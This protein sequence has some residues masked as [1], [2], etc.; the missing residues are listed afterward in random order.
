MRRLR[1]DCAIR[2]VVLAMLLTAG[3][4]SSDG[5]P[6]ATDDDQQ[7]GAKR[8]LSRPH[9]VM[10]E[11]FAKAIAEKDYKTAYAQMSAEYQKDLGEKEFLDSVKRYR[12]GC[13]AVPSFEIAATE[14]DVADLKEDSVIELLVPEN[15]RGRIVEEAV[16]RFQHG[17]SDSDDW[18]FWAVVLWVCEE[19]TGPKILNFYQDD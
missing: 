1:L 16:I 7:V 9:S 4:G 12:E 18:A 15:L 17:K 19:K 3:C 8:P 10:V 6:T 13:P 2:S 14:E 5:S 11:R